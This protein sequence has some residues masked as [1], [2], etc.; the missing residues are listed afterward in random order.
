MKYAVYDTDMRESKA[1]LVK[2][3]VYLH[4]RTVNCKSKLQVD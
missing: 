1:T 4:T 3:V 2:A